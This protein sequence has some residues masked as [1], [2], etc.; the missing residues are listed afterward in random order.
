MVYPVAMTYDGGLDYMLAHWGL[1]LNTISRIIGLPV[2]R[3]RRWRNGN[4]IDVPAEAVLVLGQLNTW[5]QE[6]ERISNQDAA[7]WLERRLVSGY[8]VTGLDLYCG[9]E[10]DALQR[11]AAG[12]LATA[13]LD[14]AVRDWRTRYDTRF[15]V[16]EADDGHAAIRMK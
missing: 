1:G 9:G 4:E 13:V 5:L 3:V 6:T 14:A 12:E 16:F 2:S 10:Q 8:T 15:E 11:I 7:S